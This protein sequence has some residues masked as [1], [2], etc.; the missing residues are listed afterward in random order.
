MTEEQTRSVLLV[1]LGATAVWLWWSGDALNYVRPGLAP[2]LL[3]GGVIVGLLGLLPPL[4]LLAAQ[5]AGHP[6]HGGH[7]R[8]R[9]RVGWLLLVPVLV[10]ILVQPTALGSYAASSRSVVPGGDNQGEFQPLAAPVRGAVPMSM[11]EF[12]TRAVRD[13]GQSLAGVRVRLVGFVAPSEGKQG[14]YRLTRFVIFCCAADAEALQA[15]VRGD[16]TPRA[17]DQWLEV[18]GTWIPRPA[19]AEDD[20]SPPP[21]ALQVDTVRPVAPARPPYEYSVQFSG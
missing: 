10:V 7:H 11:A 5:G 4:G 20:P 19:A 18:E 15:D 21:P 16:R 12:V 13:P 14:G 1:A 8:H 17:R 3:A 9:G 2:Y 6:D